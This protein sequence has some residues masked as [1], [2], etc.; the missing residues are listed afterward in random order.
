MRSTFQN[1]NLNY[2]TF[3]SAIESRAFA[4]GGYR[5]G[6][7]GQE[8]DDELAGTYSAEYWQYDAR[9]GRRWNMDPR[10]SP[11]ISVYACFANNPIWFTD[12]NGDTTK[13]EDPKSESGTYTYTPGVDYDGYDNVIC[14][15]V[16]NL[17]KL[18]TSPTGKL[19]LD[20]LH[21]MES[22]VVITRQSTKGGKK[23]YYHH[24][25]K[26]VGWDPGINVFVPEAS[27]NDY[28]EKQM[29]PFLVLGHELG[30]AW[31]Y[32]FNKSQQDFGLNPNSVW[33][34][35]KANGDTESVL[36]SEVFAVHVENLIR[37]EHGY[38]LRTHYS[39]HQVNLNYKG[40]L[41]DKASYSTF[42]MNTTTKIRIEN[43]TNNEILGYTPIGSEFSEIMYINKHTQSN[44]KYE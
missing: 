28:V 35:Y 39:L 1:T 30:H 2:Y 34:T 4:S 44:Y 27:G 17:N 41:V 12:V 36:F 10:P 20:D 11:S 37:L 19:M 26:K 7:N 6:M 13:I 38:P 43:P 18:Y 25:N 23:N 42:K 8:K 33:Y 21:S 14:E 32:H 5:Y 31:D 16:Q 40:Q 24:I 15:T 22:S 3:G 9:L 29:E